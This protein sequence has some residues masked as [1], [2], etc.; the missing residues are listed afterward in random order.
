M[1]RV[2]IWTDFRYTEE[3]KLAVLELGVWGAE[4]E[5]ERERERDVNNDSSPC[6]LHLFVRLYHS[7]T[8]GTLR[9]D[10]IGDGGMESIFVLPKVRGSVSFTEV[11]QLQNSAWHI[12]GPH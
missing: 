12:V 7:G 10:Q 5:R 8:W 3:R 9:K 2:E 4:R 6:I 1:N 11:P